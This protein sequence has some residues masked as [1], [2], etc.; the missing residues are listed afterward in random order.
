MKNIKLVPFILLGIYF[1]LIKIFNN[2][3]IEIKILFMVIIFLISSLLAIWLYK[4]KELK[5]EA[6]II[7]VIFL[8]I[9]ILS[10]AF[11]AYQI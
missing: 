1:F 4:K 9:S 5:K 7:F 11:F 8:L 2:M 10:F 3:I 6:I